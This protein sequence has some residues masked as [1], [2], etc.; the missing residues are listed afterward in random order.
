MTVEIKKFGEL[1]GKSVYAFHLKN[2]NGMELTCIEYGCIITTIKV[3]DK[4]GTFEN[5]V[6]GFD[7]L[8][9]YQK[10]SPYFGA[11]IGRVAGRIANGTFELDGKTYSLAQNNKNNHLHG[12]RKGFDKVIWK[13]TVIEN[14]SSVEF[15]YISP[16]GEEGYPG[17]LELKVTYTLNDQ[18]ELVIDYY[19]V[20]DQKTIVN[21]TNHTYFN[22]SGDLKRDILE[23]ELTLKSDQF[24]SLNEGLIPTG[25]L[26]NVE[27][28]VFDFQAGRK[29]K[30]GI[31]SSHEQNILAGNGYDHPFLLNKN[32]DQEIIL[33]DEESGRKLVI[34]T[35]E[36]SV[37]FY[38]GNQM[39]PRF[40][41]RGVQAGKYLGL[42][43]ETQG[44][45]DAI[46]HPQFPSIVLEKGE[47]YRRKTTYSF[48]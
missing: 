12:G 29:V 2:K 36:P 28:T 25:E 44:L 31:S 20:S 1:D 16:D 30:E 41:I 19:G 21:M 4:N 45:P 42:C 39:N 34:E 6:L 27:D 48:S 22:L 18:N 24:L 3:P 23:H 9:E 43:L 15:F 17:T 38:S 14:Q 47:E 26:T 10:H 33:V 11:V 35:D 40:N 37:V 13:G 46:N 5:V 8:E 7:D 32:G